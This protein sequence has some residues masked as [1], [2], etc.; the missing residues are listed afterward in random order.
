[1]C[2]YVSA[3]VEDL[4]IALDNLDKSLRDQST[5]RTA[6][7]TSQQALANEIRFHN[8]IIEHAS[9]SNCYD[10]STYFICLRV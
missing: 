1:M 5:E 6:Q 4:A 9:L 10:S 2:F 3:M 7:T 8:E